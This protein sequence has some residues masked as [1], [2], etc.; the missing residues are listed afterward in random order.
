MSFSQIKGQDRPVEI[1]KSYLKNS[2]MEG[3]YLFS[4]PQGIGKRLA[5]LTI[6]KA[7]N[8]REEGL[9]SCDQC[10]SCLKIEKFQHPD[11][12]LIAGSGAQ[13]GEENTADIKIEQIRQ[14]QKE[15]A[16]RP[17][18]A[19]KKAFIIDN[20]HNLT[21]EAENALL[22]V[23]EEPPKDSVIILVTDKPGRLFKTIISRCKVIR[24]CALKREELKEVLRSNYH[25]DADR[26]HFLAFFCE[27]RPGAAVRLKDS[28]IFKTKNMV[29]DRFI[30]S[31]GFELSRFP[32]LSRDELRGYLNIIAAA[33]RDIY[34]LKN[35]LS[36]SEIINL[37]RADELSGKAR[38][39]TAEDLDD[40]M[41]M[42]SDSVLY[43]E[44][45]VNTRLLLHNIGAV[46]WKE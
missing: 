30:F 10:A 14:L 33:L 39:F 18:E 32:A 20:A 44:Q 5:A 24:F 27:G 16:L 45:N 35:G 21:P 34:L 8:C 26:A 2:R 31:S 11:V 41:N 25:V 6:A 19:A 37:D 17:Y 7:L 29:L 42:V 3:G 23:L 36:P 9:D 43:L 1:L 22:K 13:D 40:A 46:L 15:I 28:D 4:G 12:H 38:V